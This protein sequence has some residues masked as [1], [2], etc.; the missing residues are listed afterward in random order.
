MKVKM[1]D[2]FGCCFWGTGAETQGFAQATPVLC[3]ESYPQL[4]L[5]GHGLTV[6]STLLSLLPQF[7]KGPVFIFFLVPGITS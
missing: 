3:Q 5:L 6:L 4:Y 1:L 7:G 2:L